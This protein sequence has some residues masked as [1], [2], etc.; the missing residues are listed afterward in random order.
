MVDS[1]MLKLECQDDSLTI[2]PKQENMHKSREILLDGGIRPVHSR[3][4]DIE[5]FKCPKK[6]ISK[7]SLKSHE[8]T[9]HPGKKEI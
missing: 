3:E 5:C 8:T 4:R 1:H 9:V 2:I 7:Y 6:F